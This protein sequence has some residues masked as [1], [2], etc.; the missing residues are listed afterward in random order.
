MTETT[1][2]IARPAGHRK[3]LN[4]LEGS[5]LDKILLFALPLALSSLFQQLCNSIDVAVVG[6]FSSSEALAAVGANGPVIGLMVNLFIGISIG[7]NVVIANYIGKK[8][9]Q[10]I[11]DAVSTVGVLSIVFGAVLL[12]AG[13]IIARPVLI[14][15]D[16]PENILDMAVLYLRIFFLG[17][18]F[19]IFYNFGSAILRSIGDTRRPLYCLIASGIVN[20]VLNLVLVICFDMS[21]AGVAIATAISFATSATMVLFILMHE[22]DPYRMHL[23]HSRIHWPELSRILRIG[24]PAGVQGVIFSVANL[25]I[26]AAINRFGSDAIAGSATALNFEIYSYFVVLAFGNAAITFIG[27]NYGARQM[28]RCRRIFRLS[29]GLSAL[30]LGIMGC[31][32]VWQKTFFISFFTS[33]PAVAAFAG[34]R[35]ELLLM[36]QFITAAFEIPGAALRGLGRSA[37]PTVLTVFGTCLLRLVWIYLVCPLYPSFGMLLIVYPVSWIVTGML[38]W[39][40]YL[41]VSRQLYSE[42]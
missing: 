25:F 7:A 3:H 8:N 41:L 40:A 17:M 4:P 31:L 2:P 16:T 21:V 5:L 30:A 28:D 9:V 22:T 20:T 10:G 37:L 26:Q 6:K 23:M 19:M 13:M 12:V 34:E 14:L 1:E 15:L 35:M 27:Q 33:D 36:L 32:F 18:P 29:L 42:A 11:R 38:V 24:V 39:G